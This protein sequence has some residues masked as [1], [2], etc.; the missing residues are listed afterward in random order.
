M[1]WQFQFPDDLGRQQADNVGI[2]RVFETRVD[3]F[4]NSRSTNKMAPFQYQYLLAGF[5]EIC[6]CG[7]TI[8]AAANDD[9]IVMLGFRVHEITPVRTRSFDQG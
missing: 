3:F 9:C 7:E 4:G 8:V 6:R 1:F 2:N 5:R